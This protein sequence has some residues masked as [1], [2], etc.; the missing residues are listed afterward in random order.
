[1]AESIRRANIPGASKLPLRT[2]KRQEGADAF[3][4]AA[5]QLA[6]EKQRKLIE[7]ILEA[8]WAYH[9][10]SDDYQM[11][12]DSAQADSILARVATLL[13]EVHGKFTKKELADVKDA[14]I[15]GV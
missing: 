9:Q 12:L 5:V 3:Q 13:D 1:M 4:A 7:A 2:V 6:P 14:V 10:D 11:E 15:E 8:I